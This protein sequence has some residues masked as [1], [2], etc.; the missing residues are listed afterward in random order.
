MSDR[1]RWLIYKCNICGTEI[2]R[3]LRDQND[4]EICLSGVTTEILLAENKIPLINW[5][6]NRCICRWSSIRPSYTLIGNCSEENLPL[7][8]ERDTI[9]VK[10]SV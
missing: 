2:A 4:N 7:D 1:S 3:Q 9:K 6:I 5:G 8:M 10:I